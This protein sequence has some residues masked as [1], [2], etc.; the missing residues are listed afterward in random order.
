MV[1]KPDHVLET[2]DVVVVG[3]GGGQTGPLSW[4]RRSHPSRRMRGQ[5][6][7]GFGRRTVATVAVVVVTRRR[8]KDANVVAVIVVAW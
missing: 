4:E 5:Q 1:V 2:T 7:Q 8:G 6:H 3:G